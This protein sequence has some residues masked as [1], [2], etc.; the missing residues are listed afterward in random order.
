M[1]NQRKQPKKGKIKFLVIIVVLV[2][3]GGGCF[4]WYKSAHNNSNTSSTKVVNVPTNPNSRKSTTGGGASTSP[5]NSSGSSS[6]SSTSQTN[7]LNNQLTGTP[8]QSPSGE[9]VS[10]HNPGANGSP[11][12]EESVCNVQPGVA[13]VISFTLG[14][15]TKS[16]NSQ[17]AGSSN[18]VSWSWS[19]S[20]IG[21][22]SG[23]WKVIATAS[24]NG[25]SST[26]QDGEL[27]NVQ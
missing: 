5:S 24:L 23:S 4:W 9:F 26:T 8:P 7:T 16:L 1:S 17:V 12:T 15:V 11:D 20:S 25:Y 21:L 10:N 3:L 2:L 19:P 13:C 6:A 14:N 27:L 18:S 22:T